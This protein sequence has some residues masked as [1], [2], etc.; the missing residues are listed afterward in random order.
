MALLDQL[1]WENISELP[2]LG[3]Y[4]RPNIRVLLGGKAKNTDRLL[5]M[6]PVV[7]CELSGTDSRS[8][9]PSLFFGAANQFSLE[10]QK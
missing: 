7:F 6:L 8:S 2:D 3:L 1:L 9:G 4:F 10:A 5:K